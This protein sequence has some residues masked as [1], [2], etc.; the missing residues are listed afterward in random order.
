MSESFF[1]MAGLKNSNEL[2]HIKKYT[3]E[4]KLLSFEIYEETR[5]ETICNSSVRW[6]RFFP[7]PWLLYMLY[8]DLV[9]VNSIKL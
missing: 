7:S 3:G 9:E 2:T 5:E 1:F 4:K 6:K 8:S